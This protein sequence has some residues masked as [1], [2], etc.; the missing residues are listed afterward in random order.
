MRG[1]EGEGVMYNGLQ[2]QRKRWPTFDMGYAK[3][4]CCF[5]TSVGSKHQARGGAAHTGH[6]PVLPGTRGIMAALGD[7]IPVLKYLGDMDSKH[8]L[9]LKV[10]THKRGMAL[11]A[12]VSITASQGRVCRQVKIPALTRKCG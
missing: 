11:S 12:L 6:W 1:R 4:T 5:N 8:S 10:G 3:E 7:V 2:R 9:Y